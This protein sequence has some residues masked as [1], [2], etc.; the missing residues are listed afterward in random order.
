V[1]K[2]EDLPRPD[3]TLCDH[4]LGRGLPVDVLALCVQTMRGDRVR[5]TKNR[6]ERWFLIPAVDPDRDRDRFIDH[7]QIRREPPTQPTLT[8]PWH[9]I[10]DATM[11]GRLG[12]LLDQ[13][14]QMWGLKEPEQLRALGTRS[15]RPPPSPG[16]LGALPLAT[17]ERVVAQL[18]AIA[19]D[20][21]EVS[22]QGA[23]L[24]DLR[25]LRRP[26]SNARARMARPIQ[27]I[28]S[29]IAEHWIDLCEPR[30]PEPG[31][32]MGIFDCR[33][34]APPIEERTR[35]EEARTPSG[36]RVTLLRA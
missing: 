21:A 4:L 35:F 20:L 2:E 11:A 36:R 5:E 17:L 22:R 31:M 27:T 32:K 7:Y 24:H 1:G 26:D 33:S 12:Q 29:A 6:I 15:P 10:D 8:G 13:L 19:H 14:A 25:E 23:A 30:S 3:L 28:V 9:D 16:D 34:V 18:A